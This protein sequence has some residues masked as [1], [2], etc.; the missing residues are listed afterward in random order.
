MT[1]GLAAS[2]IG[3]VT[4]P[5]EGVAIPPGIVTVP[6]GIVAVPIGIVAVPIGTMPISIGFLKT[7]IETATRLKGIVAT[8][9]R[10][11]PLVKGDAASGAKCVTV[12][13]DC[14]I[15]SSFSGKQSRHSECLEILSMIVSCERRISLSVYDILSLSIKVATPGITLSLELSF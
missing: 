6:I 4:V 9:I 15:F 12:G 1:S 13:A 7:H 14:G 5:T 2:S 3:F 11:L 8:L 10:S